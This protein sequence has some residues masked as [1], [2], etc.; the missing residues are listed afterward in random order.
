MTLAT[1]GFSVICKK[2][3]SKYLGNTWG[4]LTRG[5]APTLGRV[6]MLMRMRNGAADPAT[7]FSFFHPSLKRDG[8]SS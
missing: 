4:H 6:F 5:T 7:K 3:A 8:K 2:P 1:R